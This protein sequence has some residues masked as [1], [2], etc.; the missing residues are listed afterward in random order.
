MTDT[1]VSL[2]AS[3]RNCQHRELPERHLPYRLDIW[4]DDLG[5][6]LCLLQ[7]EFFCTG[8]EMHAIRYRSIKHPCS[9][10][11]VEVSVFVVP[12]PEQRAVGLI[13]AGGHADCSLLSVLNI[14]LF[15]FSTTLLT[16]SFD[17]C[18]YRLTIC[19][20]LCPRISAISA[21]LAPPMAR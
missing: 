9:R 5:P 20:V 21:R 6:S 7:S 1:Q 19:S 16:C 15:I 13:I 18:A 3:A 11:E 10:L 2:Y 14:W 4:S 8:L 12:Y 17:R